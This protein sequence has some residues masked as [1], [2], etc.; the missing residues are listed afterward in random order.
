LGGCKPIVPGEVTR[1]HG[2]TLL[3]DEFLEFSKAVQE[4]LREPLEKHEIHL[5][6]A[7]EAARFPA[8]FN[9]I[10]TSN[11]CPCGRLRP[12]RSVSC[13]FSLVRCRSIVERLS[14]PILDRIE[15]VAFPD[16]WVDPCGEG[17]L[18][19]AQQVDQAHEFARQTRQATEVNGRVTLASLEGQLD[20]P[21]RLVMEAGTALAPRRRRAWLRVARTL[22][23]LARSPQIGVS[24]LDEAHLLVEKPRIELAQLFA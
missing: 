10:A 20:R 22:A 24:Q 18:A 4:G 23:D 6:R 8:R 7:G 13:P 17:L 3:L 2:G 19:I 9:L 11:L 14:G 16:Q 5:S 21:A 15:I 1:A 12:G